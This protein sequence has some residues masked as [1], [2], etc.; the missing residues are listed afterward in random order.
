MTPNTSDHFQGIYDGLGLKYEAAFG[1]DPGLQSFLERGLS[2]LAPQSNVLDVG[3]GTGK[4]TSQAVV[5]AGHRLLG[6]DYSAKMIEISRQQISAG[7]F[8]RTNMLDYELED[9]AAQFDAAFVIFS[10][11]HFTRDE[12]KQAVGRFAD[13][14]AP[15]GYLFVGTMVA[16]DCPTSPEMFDPDGLAANNIKFTFMGN[17]VDVMLYT[18]VGWT[19]LLNDAGFEI[20][21]TEM[22]KFQPPPEMKTSEEPHF[23]IAARRLK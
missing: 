11:F 1:H 10:L 20:V 9:G 19:K 3:C 16:D 8:R 17:E 6:I 2:L 7:T 5:D 12:L 21:S 22:C 4:P 14:I 23:Y 13:C 15:G 18:K